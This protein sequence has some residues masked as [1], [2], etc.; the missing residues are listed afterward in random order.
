MRFLYGT[1][2]LGKQ[3]LLPRSLKNAADGHKFP[4]ERQKTTASGAFA[5]DDGSFYYSAEKTCKPSSVVCDNLSRRHVAMPLKPP[6]GSVGPTITSQSVLHRI[7]FTWQRGSPRS[8]ELLPRLSTLTGKSRR[9]LSVA[10]SLGSPPAAVSRYP[11]PGELGLSSDEGFPPSPA[12][13]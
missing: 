1:W 2:A 7:G 10:L 3:I 13:V 8:G 6:V 4:Y 12:T 9:Y 11:C 5:R